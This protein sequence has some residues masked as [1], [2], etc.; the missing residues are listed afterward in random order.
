MI[1]GL[2][3]VNIIWFTVPYVN[4]PMSYVEF[5]GTIFNLWS[6]IL[7]MKN[8]LSNFTVGLVGIALFITIFYQI[9]LYSDMFLNIIFGFISIYG[10]YRWKHPKNSNEVSLH[11]DN[12]LRIRR[13]STKGILLYS[14]SIIIGTFL[15]GLFMS[16]I[17]TLL[18]KLFPTPASFPYW[19]SFIAVSSIV[20]MIL[21]S[22]RLVDCWIIWFIV[23]ITCV[24]V[25]YSKGIMFIML[26]YFIFIIT[27]IM[28]FK[29]WTNE[30]K[31][32]NNKE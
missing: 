21:M 11:N 7:A 8:K 6:V 17:H 26:L 23:D 3:S 4:Y 20:A 27:A 13:S 22:K 9:N 32:E 31:L 30:N 18:P 19:D 29:N 25:Y 15:M 14:I 16:N 10:I 12:D 28:G 1:N 5:F 24:G 2:L